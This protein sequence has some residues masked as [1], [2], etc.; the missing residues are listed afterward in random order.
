M[1]MKGNFKPEIVV[2][3]C[4]QCVSKDADMKKAQNSHSE[5]K[6]RFLMMPCSSK[7]EASHVIKILAEGAD[8]VQVVGCKSEVCRFMVGSTMAEKR[9]EHVRR[10]LDQIRMGAERIGMIRGENLSYKEM[11]GIA[12]ERAGAVMALG[13][14]PMKG[15]QVR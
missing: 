13:P 6:A 7:V 8:G 12:E 2:L 9:I 10:L 3:Y 15:I 1:T 5:F 4:Q 14:S 11:L